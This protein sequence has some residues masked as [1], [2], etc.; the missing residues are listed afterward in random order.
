M[1]LRGLPGRGA[2]CRPR[3][4]PRPTGQDGSLS[5][6]SRVSPWR[7]T[8]RRPML[9]RG[10]V[11]RRGL[12]CVD[13]V[14]AAGGE[15]HERRGEGAPP[16][17]FPSLHGRA[18][19]QLVHVAWRSVRWYACLPRALVSTTRRHAR[20]TGTPQVGTAVDV[21][22]WCRTFNHRLVPHVPAESPCV[23]GA[24]RHDQDGATSNADEAARDA[25][26]EGGLECAP[27]A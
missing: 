7:G 13:D 20:L 22:R 12:T 19:R 26:K 15:R 11:R 10:R 17:P 1:G 25:A 2:S 9:E 4:V 18:S 27:S 23:R 5:R 6:S 8:S 16:R 21:G 24:W 3:S 14:D